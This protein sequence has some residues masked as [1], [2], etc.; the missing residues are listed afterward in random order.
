MRD[1]RPVQ[2]QIVRVK[3]EHDSFFSH[4]ELQLIGIG[5]AATS[6]LQRGQD[7]NSLSPKSPQDRAGDMLVEIET[8][9]LSQ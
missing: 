6:R 3:R 7:V 9:W 5:Q 4:R 8:D 1:A 2:R